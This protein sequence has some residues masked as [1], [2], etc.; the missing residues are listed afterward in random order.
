[1]GKRGILHCRLPLRAR[2]YEKALIMAIHDYRCTVC[3]HT[4][5]DIF[6][7]AGEIPR[8]RTC[9]ACAG[10]WWKRLWL[11]VLKLCRASLPW[12]TSA[13]IFDQACL[14]QIHNDKSSMYGKWHPQF[15]EVLQSYS[16][17]QELMKKYGLEE[18]EDPVDGNRKMSEEVF[19]DDD[20]PDPDSGEVV[21]GDEEEKVK[22]SK[23]PRSQT[24]DD[25]GL[26]P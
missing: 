8:H 25:L 21:W 12:Q 7:K 24:P 20:Q 23:D 1:M 4:E 13:Q 16:H 15:G 17:K 26:N 11:A 6:F 5:R 9:A 3:E 10:A 18:I 22:V 2:C 19:D 14:A